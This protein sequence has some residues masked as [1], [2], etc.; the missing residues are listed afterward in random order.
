[1]FHAWHVKIAKIATSSAPST[2]PGASDMKNTAVTEIK[3]STGT[4]CRMSSSGTSS[5]S[6]RRL[7]A[8]S[9]A[10]VNVKASDSASAA[11]MRNV[12]RAA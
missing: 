2:H 1:M 4:D 3:P 8:A 12:V 7:L 10:N 11:S 9:V 6:A 5:S